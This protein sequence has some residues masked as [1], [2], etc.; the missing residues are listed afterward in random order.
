VLII[1]DVP[2]NGTGKPL[3]S[4][5]ALEL[6]RSGLNYLPRTISELSVIDDS[7]ITALIYEFRSTGFK[8]TVHLVSPGSISPRIHVER[9]K[10]W[11]LTDK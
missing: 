7:H 5:E 11:R 10:L 9:A 3:T 6:V 2:F 1:T 8:D 4:D